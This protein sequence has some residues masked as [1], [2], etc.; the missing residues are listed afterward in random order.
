[1]VCS[2]VVGSAICCST[3]GAGALEAVG[4]AAV[5][6]EGSVGTA[7]VAG[8]GEGSADALFSTR[9]VEVVVVGKVL[10][11]QCF[12]PRVLQQGLECVAVERSQCF[13]LRGLSWFPLV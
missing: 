12:P 3:V 2:A 11:M 5:G 7:A 8:G 6:G 13:L 1:M 9:G 10:R 4:S